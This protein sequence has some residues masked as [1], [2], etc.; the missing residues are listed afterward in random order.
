MQWSLNQVTGDKIA[1]AT[2]SARLEK[3]SRCSST[4]QKEK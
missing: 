1:G 3:K 2:N 4:V